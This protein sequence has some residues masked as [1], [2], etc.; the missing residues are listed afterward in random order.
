LFGNNDLGRTQLV[1]SILVVVIKLNEFL[2]LPWFT[3][4]D[5]ANLILR[6]LDYSIERDMLA[7]AWSGNLILEN[8][9]YLIVD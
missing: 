5:R 9:I 2:L 6:G 8:L 4:L 7:R 1:V 3:I